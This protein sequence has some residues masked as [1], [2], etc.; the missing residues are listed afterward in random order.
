[1]TFKEKF[2]IRI[3]RIREYKRNVSWCHDMKKNLMDAEKK[4]TLNIGPTD[5]DVTPACIKMY[6]VFMRPDS[7]SDVGSVHT[8]AKY[9]PCFSDD[10]CLMYGCPYRYRNVK[11][12]ENQSLL[13]NAIDTKRASF[14]QIFER[15]K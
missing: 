6:Y 4:I 8:V 3:E 9:C 5:K 10:G 13:N 14:R 15:I 7:M 1:M 11:Y 12:K 2:N